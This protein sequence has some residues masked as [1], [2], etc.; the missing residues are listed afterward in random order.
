MKNKINFYTQKFL[1]FFI[2][3]IK[4]EF[5]FLVLRFFYEIPFFVAFRKNNPPF[6]YFRLG[7]KSE[8]IP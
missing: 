5:R 6:R 3:F 8:K 7:K 2:Y 1:F 4:L